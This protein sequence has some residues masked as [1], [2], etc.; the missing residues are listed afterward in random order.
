MED[1][2]RW[3]VT[4]TK[5][6]KQKRKVYQDGFLQL[7]S[8]GHK[9]MLYDE[10][11][12]LL[13]SRFVKKDDIINSG[14]T[15]AF[16]SYLVDIGELCG[17]HKPTF[18]LNWQEKDRK[19]AEQSGSLHRY[20]SESNSI[21]VD[22]TPTFWKRKERV[23]KLSPSEK[24]IKDFKKTAMKK[25]GSS[26]TCSDMKKT[27]TTEWQVLY[28]TQITQ[29]A[30]KFRDGFLQLVVRGSQG[31]QVMLYDSTRRHLDSRFLKKD[32]TVCSG[33]SIAFD[34]HLVEI[35]EQEGDHKPVTDST[36]HGKNWKVVGKTDVTNHQDSI[37]TNKKIQAGLS[38]L[39]I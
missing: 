16:D 31:R 37:P 22:K 27:S 24:M 3:S 12:K 14:E 30:K 17:G 32:E 21:S 11:E 7:H 35:G 15:L 4:Y 1:A 33:E 6:V 2:Q 10:S 5:H 29:K 18:N 9:V 25:Y 8:S 19:F 36:L 39:S 26:P 13:E 34:G 38:S 23:M 20:D 28:T